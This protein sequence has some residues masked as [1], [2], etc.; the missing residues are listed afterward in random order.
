MKSAERRGQSAEGR[1]QKG[2]FA[3]WV[4]VCALRTALS[5]EAR[6]ADR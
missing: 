4:V 6:H 5:S 1:A 2:V 3:G